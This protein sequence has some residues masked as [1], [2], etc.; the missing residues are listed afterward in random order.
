MVH[1]SLSLLWVGCFSACLRFSTKHLSNSRVHRVHECLRFAVGESFRQ[2]QLFRL[3]VCV[4]Y[5]HPFWTSGGLS[6]SDE[7]FP[8]EG[9]RGAFKKPSRSLQEGSAKPSRSVSSRRLRGASKAPPRTL[10]GGLRT[11]RGGCTYRRLH[12]DTLEG[13][14]ALLEGSADELHVPTRS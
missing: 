14:R 4:F 11:L 7:S 9:A 13:S 10:R 1:F 2:Q 8:N 5:S 6:L 3:C 12:E